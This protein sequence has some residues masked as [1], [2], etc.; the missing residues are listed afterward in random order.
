MKE[1]ETALNTVLNN[2]DLEHEDLGLETHKQIEYIAN[3]YII[4]KGSNFYR[5]FLT[6]PFYIYL[7]EILIN[8]YQLYICCIFS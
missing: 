8:P 4:R 7:C 6:H 2:Y 1:L 3:K 5:W